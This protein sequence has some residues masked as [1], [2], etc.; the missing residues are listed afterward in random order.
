MNN[1]IHKSECTQYIQI[2]PTHTIPTVVDNGFALWESRAIQIYLHEKYAKTDALYPTDVQRRAV[3]NQR[4]QFDMGTLYKA[5]IDFWY[6]QYMEN[7][8][9]DPVLYEKCVQAVQYLEYILEKSLFVA[10]DSLSLAD[11]SVVATVSSV[12]LAGFDLSAFP[13]TGK[14]LSTCKLIVP[15]YELN[16]AG[17][18]V[19]KLMLTKLKE[20]KTE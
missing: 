5:F 19:F 11:I 2:N 6:P 18:E 13:C 8:P 1:L 10:G 15:G 3:I 16:Q 17:L 7:K 12:E 9:A 20:G 14:W 4:L